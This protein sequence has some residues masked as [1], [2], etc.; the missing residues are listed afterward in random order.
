MLLELAAANAAFAVIKE[1]IGVISG[2]ASTKI[3]K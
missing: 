1:A 2:V 3:G